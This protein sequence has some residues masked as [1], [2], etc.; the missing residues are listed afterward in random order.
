MVEKRQPE[1][2]PTADPARPRSVISDTLWGAGGGAVFAA[3]LLGVGLARALF[4]L[5][6]GR[7]INPPNAADLGILV[8]YVGALVVVGGALGAAKPLLRTRMGK[9]VGFALGGAVATTIIGISVWAHDSG[10]AFAIPGGFLIATA[11]FGAL[12]GC[13]LARGMTRGTPPAP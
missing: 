2:Q 10:R 12:L 9:Y 8:S 6:F 5:L 4:A 3:L 11:V 7:R 13:A 1:N